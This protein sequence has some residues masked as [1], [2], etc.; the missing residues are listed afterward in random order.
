MA[1]VEPRDRARPGKRMPQLIDDLSDHPDTRGVISGRIRP[2]G[3]KPALQLT[4]RHTEQLGDRL[5]RDGDGLDGARQ[6]VADRGVLAVGLIVDDIAQCLAELLESDPNIPA[7]LLDVVVAQRLL[8]PKCRGPQRCGQV[9]VGRAEHRFEAVDQPDDLLRN[10]LRPLQQLGRVID[11]SE[12]IA[13]LHPCRSHVIIIRQIYAIRPFVVVPKCRA[14]R[15]DRQG[16][17]AAEQREPAAPSGPA[18]GRPSA[19]MTT[20]A[21][22]Q[23]RKLRRRCAHVS[24]CGFAQ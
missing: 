3:A 19:G 16:T 5:L 13:Q 2:I 6:H 1:P 8:R 12:E 21:R 17:R 10:R 24:E 18:M 11:V 22:S 23:V 20:T 15:G 14:K 9:R 7:L 4:N